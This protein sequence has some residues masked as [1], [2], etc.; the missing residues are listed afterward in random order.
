MNNA[1]Y[2]SNTKMHVISYNLTAGKVRI[3]S[4]FSRELPERA[5]FN[6]VIMDSGALT[7]FLADLNQT[8]GHLFQNAALTLESSAVQAK[9]LGVPEL[10]KSQYAQIAAQEIREGSSEQEM[11]FDYSL[12]NGQDKKRY[13][14][15]CT[16][17]REVVDNYLA[18]FRAAGIQIHHMYVGIEMV[19]N[20]VQTQ[21]DLCRGVVV[22][23][24][25]DDVS[26]LSIIFDNGDY[27]FSTRTRMVPDEE[28]SYASSALQSISSL[29]KFNPAI[30][31]SYYAGAPA[32]L[33]EKMR[34]LQSSPD[35]GFEEYELARTRG[36][37]AF[38]DTVSP[39]AYFSLF[40]VEDSI[41]LVVACKATQKKKK[42]FPKRIVA[43]VLAVAAIAAVFVGLKVQTWRLNSSNQDI[44]SALN[45]PENVQRL[46]DIDAMQQQTGRLN[47][48]N[49]TM[50]ATIQDITDY[51]DF[52]ASTLD[53][54]EQN[55]GTS[56]R[57][58]SLLFDAPS[59]VL[60]VTGV[61]T[62]Q[63]DASDFVRRIQDYWEFSD[64]TYTGYATNQDGEYVFSLS[65]T[66]QAQAEQESST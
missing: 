4:T 20:Y 41:D 49:G 17:P 13:L 51:K 34:D 5:I 63:S 60:Q 21:E 29:T 61:S 15:L 56:V 47:Q 64:V 53:W 55:A 12:L 14:F 44:T 40:H 58:T 33:V 9:K 38:P 1:I 65:I 19:I 43:A 36:S 62:T 23:N 16:V 2:L 22:F 24:V 3:Q 50:N 37:R 42:P 18:I 35:M 7:A 52:N 57:L 32:G 31:K 48:V 39:F 59:Q 11:V 10:K 54:L 28:N 30:T 8:D 46:A 25:L 27:V 26:M 45:A 66:L 6:G